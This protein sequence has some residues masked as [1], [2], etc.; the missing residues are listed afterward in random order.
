MINN[1][2][3]P[4]YHHPSNHEQHLHFVSLCNCLSLLSSS[5]C[6]SG[7]GFRKGENIGIIWK[8]NPLKI[9][10]ERSK[11]NMV[12]CPVQFSITD[13]IYNRVLSLSHIRKNSF[14]KS[15]LAMFCKQSPLLA[16]VLLCK[17]LQGS[18]LLSSEHSIS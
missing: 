3:I 10:F 4:R 7:S 1:K 16:Q 6:T 9:K 2:G 17:L 13:F 5:C 14:Y 11:R 8:Q 18:V 12:G 15:K